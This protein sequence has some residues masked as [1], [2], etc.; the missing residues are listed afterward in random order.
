MKTYYD[1]RLKVIVEPSTNPIEITEFLYK[2]KAISEEEIK[3]RYKVPYF[4]RPSGGTTALADWGLVN[5]LDTPNILEGISNNR[6]CKPNK[7]LF[8][9]QDMKYY[10][11]TYAEL[12]FMLAEA[13]LIFLGNDAKAR[14]YYEAGIDA[15]FQ[16]YG[17]SSEV[18]IYKKRPGIEWG[19]YFVGDFDLFKIVNSG[20]KK[21]IP[22]NTNLDNLE[23]IV[24]QLWLT[25]YNQGHD[26]WCLQKR[27][28]LL[29]L[30][31]N[32]STDTSIG[33]V[34]ADIPER[35]VYPNS[36]FGI[37]NAGYLAALQFLGG[38]ELNTRL[39]MNKLSTLPLNYWI[40]L[41]NQNYSDQ[42]RIDIKFN[43]EFALLYG[44]SE[45]EFI[46]R[47]LVKDKD[48]QIIGTLP[49]LP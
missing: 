18:E 40:D 33:L 35:M 8:M 30:I 7:D 45:S 28:R 10:I 1:P 17:V 9:A 29:P 11:V 2:D 21:T 13:N 41:K 44:T 22:T 37:N 15:S 36:E 48:Y 38:N 49:A 19:T 20:F 14:Q 43:Q 32:F 23:K 31:P 4:G 39:K 42:T 34:Y 6:Y 24:R 27:T 5:N 46:A 16:Q 25:S 47:G 12:N 26:I 3:V